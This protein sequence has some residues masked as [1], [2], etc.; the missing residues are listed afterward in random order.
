MQGARALATMAGL[1][2][3]RAGSAVCRR[4]RARSVRP[5]RRDVVDRP[6]AARR[7]ASSSAL[8]TTSGSG[9]TRASG[10]RFCS[11]SNTPSSSRPILMVLGFALA[12]LTADNTPLKRLTRTI[13]FL[14]V[15]IGLS[16]SS[17]LWFW[18]FD[19]QVGLFNKLLV[20]LHVIARADRLVRH[21][22][23]RLLGG[24]DFHHLEGRRLRHGAVRRRHPVDQSG[25]SRG[26]GHRRRRLLE[27]RPPDHPAAD[28]ARAAPDDAGQRDRL[29]AG[30]RPVLH[31][32]LGRAAGGRPSPPSIGS[33]RTRS[34]RSDSAM[35]RRCRS[36]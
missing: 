32:D 25:H 30:L 33:T 14:P 20:D 22:R 11:R 35:A 21:R 9:T 28:P 34:C 5:A 23:S 27:P 12:L 6:L 3:H 4:V 16:S 36:C 13:V 7:A 19:E 29:D 10:A 17:L 24:G 18:L 31:H 2:V 26:G 15:V 1:A 8:A